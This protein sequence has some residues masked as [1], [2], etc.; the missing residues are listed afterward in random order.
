MAGFHD[1]GLSC[2]IPFKTKVIPETP[3]PQQSLRF[4]DLEVSGDYYI[5]DDVKTE[6]KDHTDTSSL[7][8]DSR[9]WTFQESLLSNR[10]ICYG[11]TKIFWQCKEM[12]RA[13]D[14][15]K[16]YDWQRSIG[17]LDVGSFS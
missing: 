12:A 5:D 14:A 11:R 2:A 1:S 15:D 16:V 3:S 17:S 9:G 6:D 7:P 13:D 10:M 4:R 8:L